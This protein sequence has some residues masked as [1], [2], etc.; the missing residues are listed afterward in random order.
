[1][2]GSSCSHGERGSSLGEAAACSRLSSSD[3]LVLLR[4]LLFR[5]DRRIHKS[6]SSMP[7]GAAKRSSRE[8]K[9]HSWRDPCSWNSWGRKSRVEG[10][11]AKGDK[12]GCQWV[13]LGTWPLHGK[14]ALALPREIRETSSRQGVLAPSSYFVK[15]RK[16]EQAAHSRAAARVIRPPQHWSSGGQRWC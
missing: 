8:R 13:G 6:P 4:R 5:V 15:A 9:S 10:A 16:A 3:S 12:D 7:K 11:A 1:M 2:R 14:G